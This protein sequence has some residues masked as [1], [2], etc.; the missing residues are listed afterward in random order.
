MVDNANGFNRE[1]RY[2]RG[3]AES[4]EEAVCPAAS[5]LHAGPSSPEAMPALRAAPFANPLGSERFTFV[6]LFAGIGGFRV[7]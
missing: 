4:R 2:P 5:P 1:G 7:G 3:L 6:D